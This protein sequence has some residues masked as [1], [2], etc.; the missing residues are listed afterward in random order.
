[1]VLVFIGSLLVALASALQGIEAL[2]SGGWTLA[3][4]ISIPAWAIASFS[5]ML[6]GLSAWFGFMY[7][8]GLFSG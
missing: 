6:S 7:W 2:V 1:M 3:G 8:R 4:G 5:F